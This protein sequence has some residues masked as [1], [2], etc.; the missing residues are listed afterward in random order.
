MCT[1]LYILSLMNFN[2]ANNIDEV[3]VQMDTI[4]ADCI[5]QSSRLGYFA[6]LYKNVTISIKHA[7]NNH[8]FEDGKRMEHLDVVFA[9]R[10]INAYHQY[11]QHTNPT[12]AWLKTFECANHS[13]LTIIQHLLLGMNAHIN[14]DLG[15]AAAE[16]SN[17][18]NIA[19]LHND[20]LKINIVLATAYNSMLAKLKTI[21]WPIV[22][23]GELNPVITS[24]VVNF[25]IEKARNQAW[26]NAL[27]MCEAGLE[28]SSQIIAITDIVITKVAGAIQ[29]P[30]WI[31]AKILK[32]IKTFESNDVAK[33]LQNF[34]Q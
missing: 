18:S 7:I 22:M 13:E 9:N 3:I 30:S 21:S 32:F 28:N 11:T 20:F 1:I 2:T 8:F 12:N 29:N 23:L 10:Y 24:Q 33:N 27:L 25:S 6:I 4:I 34:Y 26:A 16:I 15:I 31:T 17:A 19:H 14:L 5:K